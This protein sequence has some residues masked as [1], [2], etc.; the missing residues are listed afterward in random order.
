MLAWEISCFGKNSVS[1]RKPYLFR[2]FIP[3]GAMSD[4]ARD[5]SLVGLHVATRPYTVSL[6]LSTPR[7]PCLLSRLGLVSVLVAPPQ[8]IMIHIED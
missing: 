3:K 1:S 2:I 7:V 6:L 5:L 4:Y 8:A